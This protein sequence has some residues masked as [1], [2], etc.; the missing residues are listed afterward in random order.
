MLGQSR[1]SRSRWKASVEWNGMEQANVA[2]LADGAGEGAG[3]LDVEHQF[4]KSLS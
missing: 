1:A 2:G 4:L 3:S